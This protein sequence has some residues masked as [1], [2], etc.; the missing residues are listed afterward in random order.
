MSVYTG[1]CSKRADGRIRALASVPLFMMTIA[2]THRWYGGLPH[3]C[4]KLYQECLE[5]LLGGKGKDLW[6]N[7]GLGSAEK[8]EVLTPLAYHMHDGKTRE[9]REISYDGLRSAIGGKIDDVSVEEF[10]EEVMNRPGLLV[11]QRHHVY[12]FSHLPFQGY[13]TVLHLKNRNTEAVDVLVKRK[14]KEWWRE[15]MLLYCKLAGADAL[16]RSSFDAERTF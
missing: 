2:T 16:L 15:T 11:Q 3:K 8:L 10:L 9:I 13:L 12:A 5:L 14:D 1:T 4:H 7:Q 6:M